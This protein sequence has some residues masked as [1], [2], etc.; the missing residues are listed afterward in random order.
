MNLF[1]QKIGKLL[2]MYDK[3]YSQA[4]IIEL[5]AIGGLGYCYFKTNLR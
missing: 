1:R 2:E 4:G 5:V 3:I